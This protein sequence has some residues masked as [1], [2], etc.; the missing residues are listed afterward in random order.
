MARTGLFGGAFKG[1]DG[2]G[3]TMEDVKVKTRTGAFLTVLS[4]AIILIFTIIE[5]IDYRRVAVDSM[6]LVDRSRGDRMS[7]KMNVTFPRVPCYRMSSVSS[8]VNLV[9]TMVLVLSMDITDI[10]GEIM[11]DF[12]HNM[13]KTRLSSSG[14]DLHD[15]T[16]NYELH[17]AVKKTI[18]SRPAG[19]CGSCYGADP[20]SGGCC[21]TCE[22]VRDAYINRGWSFDDPDVIEQVC[23]ALSSKDAY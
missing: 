6:I 7:V 5:A 18:K 12:T 21:Q 8:F 10:S 15:N 3:K 16:L 20:I 9:L 1:L 17:N 23:E 2:F 13:L 19:Y 14:E 11:Q 4:A 22:S